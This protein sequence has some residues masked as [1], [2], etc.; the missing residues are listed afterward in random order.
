MVSTRLDMSVFAPLI[1]LGG[2]DLRIQLMTDL[3]DFETALK[4]YCLTQPGDPARADQHLGTV[5]HNLRGLSATIGAYE[6]VNLCQALEL[7]ADPADRAAR[8]QAIAELIDE[9]AQTRAQIRQRSDLV[10]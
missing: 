4:T 5:L 9:I 8:L 6:L 1:S 7:P 3:D 10:A 2:E